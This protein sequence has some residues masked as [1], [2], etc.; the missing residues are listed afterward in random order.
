MS[1]FDRHRDGAPKLPLSST[2]LIG[3]FPRCRGSCLDVATLAT[4]H[5]PLRAA[6]EFLIVTLNSKQSARYE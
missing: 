6:Q 5:R 2:R 1:L 4:G 3:N